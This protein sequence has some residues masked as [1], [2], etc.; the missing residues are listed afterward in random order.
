MAKKVDEIMLHEQY[1][2]GSKANTER[3]LTTYTEANP[4]RSVYAFCINPKHPG[5]F[6]LCFKAGQHAQL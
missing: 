6:H 3:W 4:I 2:N 1:Q 5:Y